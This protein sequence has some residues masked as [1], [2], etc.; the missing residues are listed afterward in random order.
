MTDEFDDLK[1][2]FRAEKDLNPDPA[3]KA[4]G[5]AKAMDRYDEIFSATSQGKAKGSRLIE[6]VRGLIL[7]STKM[8]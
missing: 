3:A 1:Q 7:G 8:H 4:A 5:I 2:Q 6:R